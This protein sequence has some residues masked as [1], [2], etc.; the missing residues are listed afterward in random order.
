M[1]TLIVVLNWNSR[2]M[3]EQCLQSLLAMEKSSFQILVV[4]NGSRDGSVE[5]LRNRFPQ[6]Q[7]IAN[8]RNL[9]FAVGCNVGIRQGLAEDADYVLLVNNDTIIDPNLLSELLAEARE[10]QRPEFFLPRS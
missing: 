3:T 6:I 7:V 8:G 4:D 2:E 1:N 10:T 9:G 5:Y